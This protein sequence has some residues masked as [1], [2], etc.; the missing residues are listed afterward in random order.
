MVEIRSISKGA[1]D[2]LNQDRFMYRVMNEGSV[3]AV[4]CDGMGGLD[5]GEKASQIVCDCMIEYLS[6]GIGKKDVPDLLLESFAYANTRLG[7]AANE[8]HAKMGTAVLALV[9]KDGSLTLAWQGN[10]RAYLRKIGNHIQQLT[11]D[12]VLEIGYGKKRLTRCLKGC[13]LREDIPVLSM[14]LEPQDEIIMC[15]DGYYLQASI[16]EVTGESGEMEGL[17]FSDDATVAIVKI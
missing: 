16:T 17:K 9:V 14:P 10:V 15:T 4:M 13:V 12:H 8:L 6:D 7:A 5:Y 1:A 11:T 3:V 2:T